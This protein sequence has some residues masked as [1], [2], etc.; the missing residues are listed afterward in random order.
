ML[1]REV[2]VVME[3]MVE[4]SGP[5]YLYCCRTKSILCQ[6]LGVWSC[7]LTPCTDPRSIEGV[8]LF[9]PSDTEGKVKF[10]ANLCCGPI[11]LCGSSSTHL[12]ALL[13][14]ICYSM[15]L[16]DRTDAFVFL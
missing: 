16:F 10:F 1:R 4:M 2:W 8:H 9:H 3:R 12:S 7:P 14:H 15:E 11:R 6:W 5:G 13:F